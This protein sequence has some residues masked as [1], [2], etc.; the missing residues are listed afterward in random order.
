M[1]PM[2]PWQEI[3]LADYEAHMQ[4]DAV[5]QASVLSAIFA[6]VLEL[7]R[8]ASVAVLGIAGGNGLERIDQSLTTRVVGVDLNPQYITTVRERFAHIAWL[9]LYAADLAK[10]TLAVAPVELVHSALVFE[11]AGLGLCLENAL[12]MM[13][14]KGALSVVVQLPSTESQFVGSSGVTS[15]SKIS[16]HFKLVDPTALTSTL[17]KHGLQLIHEN[18]RA[19][20]AGKQL[21]LGV[22]ARG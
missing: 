5:G 20:P 13:A 16:S 21:W 9:E 18:T 14:P 10:D 22:F 4:S 6:E 3:P 8:P 11:H 12:G 1:S 15:M 19:V 7:R 2:N 17:A